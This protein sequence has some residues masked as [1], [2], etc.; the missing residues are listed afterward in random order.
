MKTPGCKRSTGILGFI[1]FQ[2]Y[3]AKGVSQFSAT[4]PGY[5]AKSFML[6]VTTVTP[7]AS[8]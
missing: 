5:L 4:T 6:L 1:G 7:S 8:A 2:D 3:R